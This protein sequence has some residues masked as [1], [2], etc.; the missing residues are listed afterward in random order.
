MFQIGNRVV[1]KD[2]PDYNGELVVRTEMLSDLVLH[3]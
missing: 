2:S 1:R 3:D